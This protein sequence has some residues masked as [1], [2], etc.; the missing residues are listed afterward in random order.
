[1][2]VVYKDGAYTGQIHVGKL[3]ARRFSLEFGDR[4]KTFTQSSNSTVKVAGQRVAFDLILPTG[5]VV[6]FTAVVDDGK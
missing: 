5:G 1:M 4:I 6:A 2:N 3:P